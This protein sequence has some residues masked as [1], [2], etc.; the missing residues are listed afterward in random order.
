MIATVMAQTHMDRERD[1]DDF[2]AKWN[3]RGVTQSQK[4]EVAKN[5]AYRNN[6]ND[7]NAKVSFIHIL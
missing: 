3:S 2:S 4:D 5:Q 7:V 1:L 6:L